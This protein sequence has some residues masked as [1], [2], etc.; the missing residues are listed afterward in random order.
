MGY[1]TVLGVVGRGHLPSR[2]TVTPDEQTGH[3]VGE[4]VQ[5]R[6]YLCHEYPF[7]ILCT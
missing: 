3:P 2:D 4:T 6:R 1:M 7:K 5:G